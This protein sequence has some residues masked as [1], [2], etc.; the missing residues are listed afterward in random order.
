MDRVEK[1]LQ[2][3]KQ[4]NIN[5]DVPLTTRTIRVFTNCVISTAVCDGGNRRRI[6]RLC[7]CRRYHRI[8]DDPQWENV[9]VERIVRHITRRK[10]IRRSSS[11]RWAMNPA[12][13]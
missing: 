1:D 10:T 2:L 11:G 9:Y 7:Q 4:H 6:A 8:T 13:L 3:M 5:S 12:W